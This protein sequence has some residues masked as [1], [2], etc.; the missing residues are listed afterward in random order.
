[1]LLGLESLINAC[2]PC[3]LFCQR[4]E[5]QIIKHLNRHPATRHSDLRSPCFQLS[6]LLRVRL[7][8]SCSCLQ[9]L[10]PFKF[11]TSSQFPKAL[12]ISLY[13]LLP[14]FNRQHEAFSP[15][16]DIHQA[17]F[18]KKKK[19]VTIIIKDFFHLPGV[20]F[21]SI[22]SPLILISCTSFHRMATN[23]MHKKDE[24][25]KYRWDCSKKKRYDYSASRKGWTL[26]DMN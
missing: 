17:P 6:F 10:P 11:S 1:M 16:K 24:H 19:E 22:I 4:R 5:Y 13:Y 14:F 18:F 9:K 2:S 25:R 7:L 3:L 12:S 8:K 26:Y 20:S 21:P 23:L 15:I